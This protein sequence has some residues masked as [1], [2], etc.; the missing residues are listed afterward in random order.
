MHHV[1]ESPWVMRI[2]LLVLAIGATA[3]GFIGYDFFVGD[4]RTSFWKSSIFV[5]PQFD[6][7]AKVEAIPQLVRFMPL[8]FGL[9]GIGTAY[10]FYIVDRTL[11]V[12]LAQR[13]RALYLFLL[14]KWYFDDLYDLV[15]VRTAF[16]LGDVL[17]K[18]GDG[19]LID[20]LGPNGVAA[21]TRDLSRQASRLQTGYLYHYAFVMLIGVAAFVTW[22]L[23]PR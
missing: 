16:V 3:F 12:R 7:L 9:A 18:D 2:P 19:L 13:F 14:N 15:F 4:E 20:G 1:H 22:Y 5:L 17:W 11:P 8:I 6:S 21:L 23:L 10:V